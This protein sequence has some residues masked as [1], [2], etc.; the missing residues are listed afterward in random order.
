MHGVNYITSDDG[1]T[2][3]AAGLLEL[4]AD[5]AFVTM[6]KQSD[7]DYNFNP[8][9]PQ[10]CRDIIGAKNIYFMVGPAA[11]GGYWDATKVKSVNVTLQTI[12][13]AAAE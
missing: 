2:Q 11:S 13:W 3:Y 10:G 6:P 4:I 9:T 8:V 1:K 5:K 12:S 7:Y